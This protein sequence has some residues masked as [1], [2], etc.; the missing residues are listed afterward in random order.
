[1]ETDKIERNAVRRV[2]EIVDRSRILKPFFEKGGSYPIWDG[3]IFVYKSSKTSNDNY[4]GKINVQIKGKAVDSFSNEI[5]K[6]KFE[7][8]HLNAFLKDLGVLYFVV[9]V[10]SSNEMRVYYRSFLPV[11]LDSV[12]K[13]V[14]TGQ[15][16]KIEELYQLDDIDGS[17]IEKVCNEFLYHREMQKSTYKQRIKYDEI[18]TIDR[19]SFKVFN[20]NPNELIDHLLK[21]PVMIY[22]Y[23]KGLDIPFP[24]EYI[25]P[26]KIMYDKKK[27]IR[28][29]G[30]EYYSNYK[31]EKYQDKDILKIGNGIELDFARKKLVY[32][33]VGK[34][35]DVIQD[36]TFLHELSIYGYF[37]ISD[38]SK[39]NISF[40]QNFSQ[41]VSDKKQ[42]FENIVAVLEFF[43]VS[44]A[45]LVESLT[46]N[47]YKLLDALINSIIYNSQ[48]KLDD[49]CGIISQKIGNVNIY[50][51]NHIDVDG[52]CIIYNLF[53][54]YE[55][56]DVVIRGD[57]EDIQVEGSIFL[58]FKVDN[59]MDLNENHLSIIS[60]D[61]LRFKFSETY[62]SYLNLL[63]LEFIKAYDL[64]KKLD[65]LEL[66]AKIENWII[67]NSKNKDIYLINKIQIIKRQRKLSKNEKGVLRSISVRNCENN[68]ILCGI[69]IL[70]E[71]WSDFEFYFEKLNDEDRKTFKQFPIFDLT[72]KL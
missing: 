3:S 6:H 48:S 18:D 23:K 62:A 43:K 55:F 36:Y 56:I 60:E 52:N 27:S 16:S 32:N 24:F 25:S 68:Q 58:L 54:Y 10:L 65:Y 30:N 63:A 28:I 15:K 20:N 50:I 38:V 21:N 49:N 33:N 29:N 4:E 67:E 17:L 45:L 34:I 47:D 61:V 12:L 2:E 26:E 1:M 31:V 14:K 35:Y 13:K 7:V 71:N 57:S 19:L 11:D 41:T 64:C 39:I 44:E 22:G 69:S 72:K 46:H 70:L 40:D 53:D 59:I 42:Y 8:S 66:A 37:E 51:Y 9:Q 5:I